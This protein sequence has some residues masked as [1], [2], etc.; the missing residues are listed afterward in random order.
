MH[1][2]T[3]RPGLISRKYRA[4]ELF[5]GVIDG[6]QNVPEGAVIKQEVERV[7]ERGR[8]WLTPPSQQLT[9]VLLQRLEV[10]VEEK[11]EREP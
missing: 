7:T 10:Q 8:S 9:D 5:V 1:I 11:N 6:W 4:P 2:H 3:L